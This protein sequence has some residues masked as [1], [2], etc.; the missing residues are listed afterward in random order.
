MKISVLL[1]AV[2]VSL[3]AMEP[4]T[5]IK[6]TSR[7]NSQNKN[8]SR[9]RVDIPSK[10]R[11]MKLSQRR[12][13]EYYLNRWIKNKS[14]IESSYYLKM[15]YLKV[16][17]GWAWVEAKVKYR[18]S[19]RLDKDINALMRLRDNRWVVVYAPKDS[20]KRIDRLRRDRTIQR[21]LSPP[22]NAPKTLFE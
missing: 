7:Y 21:F 3:V 2:G 18:N 13:I 22:Y 8:E 1:C 4:P 17:N 11:D 19:K 12:E 14:N 16:E 6:A 20:I 5:L 9:K 10:N 15:E